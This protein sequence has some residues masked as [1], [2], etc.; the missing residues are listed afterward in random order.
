MSSSVLIGLTLVF[1]ALILGAFFL[2]RQRQSEDPVQAAALDYRR[3]VGG[4][5]GLLPSRMEPVGLA[6]TALT[7]VSFV[8]A[9]VLLFTGSSTLILAC[10]VMILSNAFAVRRD[11]EWL[12]NDAEYQAILASDGSA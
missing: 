6:L 12:A 2:A 5:L 11:R 9:I 7:G 1:M 3:R 8:A 4:P 10:G